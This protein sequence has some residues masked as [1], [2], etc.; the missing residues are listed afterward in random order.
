MAAISGGVSFSF[1]GINIMG[2]SNGN[3]WGGDGWYKRP[4]AGGV[5]TAQGINFD[6]VAPTAI[7]RA[8]AL[9]GIVDSKVGTLS[10]WFNPKGHLTT[11]QI[12][13]DS[14]YGSATP[15]SLGI[16]ASRINLSCANAANTPILQLWTANPHLTAGWKHILASWDLSV[17][18]A[19]IYITDVDD[20][21]TPTLTNDLIPYATATAQQWW[22]TDP[23]APMDMDL[24]DLWLDTNT[25][26]DLTVTANRRKFISAA[27]APV[28]LGVAGA[29]PTGSSPMIFF[30]GNNGA[31]AWATNLGTGGAFALDRGALTL[32]SSNPP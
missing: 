32:A 29:T 20:T 11:G 6:F 14:N 28:N 2:W 3:S 7:K 15:V 25:F 24:A 18:T 22:N 5:Y 26:I 1:R 17:P 19:K 21:T 9:T 23:G 10:V 4:A 13:I 16:D 30:T 31:A 12:I 27:Q 8:G